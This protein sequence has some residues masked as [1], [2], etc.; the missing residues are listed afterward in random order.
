MRVG[1]CYVAVGGDSPDLGECPVCGSPILIHMSEQC[2]LCA[3]EWDACA[4]LDEAG[5]HPAD[6][7]EDLSKRPK[8]SGITKEAAEYWI[9]VWKKKDK[10]PH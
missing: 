7:Y 6:V 8:F 2:E 1:R 3:A 10:Q 4:M 9:W 5:F